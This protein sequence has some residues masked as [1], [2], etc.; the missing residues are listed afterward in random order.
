MDDKTHTIL[1]AMNDTGDSDVRIDTIEFK[2]RVS[3]FSDT[4]HH[5]KTP[6]NRL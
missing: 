2:K 6:G 1:S 3:I 4:Q 5:L